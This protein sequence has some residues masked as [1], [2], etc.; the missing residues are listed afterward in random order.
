MVKHYLVTVKNNS[1]V[2]TSVEELRE[3]LYFANLNN[4]PI[5]SDFVGI[6]L[7]QLNRL[8]IHTLLTTQNNI[9]CKGQ[10]KKW[11]ELFHGGWHINYTAVTQKTLPTVIGYITKEHCS[12]IDLEQISYEHFIQIKLRTL[13]LFSK[14][15]LS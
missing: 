15:I 4:T 9:S 11:K 8:H 14:P 12:H 7:D 10:A 5:K 13:N 6:E 2:F 3:A 1:N